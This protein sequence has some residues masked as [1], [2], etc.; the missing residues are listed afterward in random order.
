MQPEP[1]VGA[2]I[3]TFNP[4]MPVLQRLVMALQQQVDQLVIVDNSP[5]SSSDSVGSADFPGCILLA[6]GVNHGIAVGLNKGIE[7]LL[8]QGCDF[9]LLSDQD[10]LPASDMV[11]QL[12]A[13]Q[14]RLERAGTAVAAVGPTFVDPRSGVK[15]PFQ[16]LGPL[17]L[18][19]VSAPD[20]FGCIK[21]SH[22][23]S[24]GTLVSLQALEKLGLMDAGLFIDYVDVEWCLRG[25]R[26]GLGS[27]GVPEATMHHTIG[28]ES[29]QVWLFGWRRRSLH[30]PF[31]I[32]YQFRNVLWL[33]FMRH[34]PFA[35]KF[36]SLLRLPEKIYL[37]LAWGGRSRR[38]YCQSI[39]RGLRDGLAGR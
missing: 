29:V 11:A 20:H 25:W 1:K 36:W 30:S 37:Y 15:E 16:A 4:D 18:R 31:R 14:R 9:F 39:M 17:G 24:S 21:A 6:D 23:I 28:D 27:Y 3:V 26:Q 8:G 38:E 34:I 13:A 2:V 19:F 22:L 7:A 33:C 10:S 35:W 12:L 5:A 32:Y